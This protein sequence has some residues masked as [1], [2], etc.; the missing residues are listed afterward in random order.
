MLLNNYFVNRCKHKFAY[1]LKRVKYW[2]SHIKTRTT[3]I[4][5]MYLTDIQWFNAVKIISYVHDVNHVT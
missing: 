4:T 3:I 5:Y 1:S 2:V